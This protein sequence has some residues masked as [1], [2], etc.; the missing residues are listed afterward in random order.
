MENKL[1]SADI[2]VAVANYFKPRV[3]LIVPNISWGMNLHECD[4]LILNSS[5]YA[6]EVEIKISKADIKAD[7]KKRH[8]HNSD[9]I[10]RLFFAIPETLNTKDV[11]DLIPERAGIFAV[12]NRYPVYQTLPYG[13]PKKISY[14]MQPRCKVIRNAQIN[15]NARPFT[16]MERINVGRLGMLRYWNIRNTYKQD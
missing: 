10:R 5:N 3:N 6:I 9:R 1:T 13:D 7:L 11:I 2:E 15:K 4:V 16:D 14:W 8:G 12:S